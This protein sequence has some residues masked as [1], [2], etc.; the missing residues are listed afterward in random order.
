MEGSGLAPMTN[1]VAAT[2]L[3][4]IDKLDRLG[5]EGVRSLLGRRRKDKCGDFTNGA[6][7]DQSGRSSEYSAF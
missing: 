7:L 2:V 1:A 3:R 5:L 6:G 4:A